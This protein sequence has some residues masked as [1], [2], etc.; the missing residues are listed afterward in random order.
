MERSVDPR[1]LRGD[2]GRRDVEERK[3]VWKKRRDAEMHTGKAQEVLLDATIVIG[4][5]DYW[6]NQIYDGGQDQEQE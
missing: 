3:V 1:R 6:W 4:L 2:D 5:R